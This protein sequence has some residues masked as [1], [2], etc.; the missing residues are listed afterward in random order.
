MTAAPE[1]PPA[2]R[3]SLY[4]SIFIV[5][6]A[7]V[8]ITRVDFQVEMYELFHRTPGGRLGHIVGTLAT[9]L[10]TLALSER[11]SGSLA[12]GVGL[13][14]AIAL[15]GAAVDRLVGGLTA[16]LGAAL[17]ALVHFAAPSLG[18]DLTACALGLVFGGCAVQTFSH[19]FEDVPPPQS[20]STGFVP[21]GRWLRGI[22]AREVVRST[23]LTLLVFYWL[24]LWATFRIWPLQILHV[25][26]RLGYRPEAR[27]RLDA[28][29]REIIAHP[30]S[31]WRRPRAG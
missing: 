28:R 23:L 1:H 5:P 21:V 16:L 10:G 2:P 6:Q 22:T 9:L 31:D 17:V 4:E 8:A 7:H 18:A 20:G 24:E 11:A 12:P 13:L 3:P 25:L 27:R 15:W 14:A 26:M 29:V 19:L 30:T